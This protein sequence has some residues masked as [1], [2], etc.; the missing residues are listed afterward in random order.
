MTHTRP[1]RYTKRRFGT[2]LFDKGDHARLV[3]RGPPPPPPCPA[4]SF[5]HFVIRAFRERNGFQAAGVLITFPRACARVCSCSSL[6]EE[7]RQRHNRHVRDATPGSLEQRL[8]EL[9]QVQYKPIQKT[10][11]LSPLLVAR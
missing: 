11:R 10:V 9:E 4:S 5:H 8:E 7:S 3:E 1:A 2:K 6:G